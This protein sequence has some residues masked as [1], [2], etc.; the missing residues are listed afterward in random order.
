[1][2]LKKPPCIQ[3]INI[4]T[5]YVYTCIFILHSPRPET[6]AV[7]TAMTAALMDVWRAQKRW[8]HGGSAAAD[9]TPLRPR[10]PTAP[11][12]VL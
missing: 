10:A 4:H 5:T 3:Y 6:A 9:V 2:L 7:A 12:T 11:G 8:G 1:M